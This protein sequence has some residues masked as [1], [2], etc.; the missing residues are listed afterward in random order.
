MFI[1]LIEPISII[2]GG[3][4]LGDLNVDRKILR[5]FMI[6]F[7]VFWGLAII[8]LF[9]FKGKTC[10]KSATGEP[11]HLIWDHSKIFKDVPTLFKYLGFLLYNV[12][13]ILLFYMKNKTEG[14]IY[15]FLFYFSLFISMAIAGKNSLQW[16]SYW[17]WMVNLVPL[18]AIGIGYYYHRK[19][20]S[21]EKLQK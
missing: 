5:N 1:L 7:L 17:C 13:G 18:A 2:V 16:K 20:K 3:Y 19:R 9:L 14:G 15:A 6:F 10:S 4:Y 12:S 8:K 21:E 11:G